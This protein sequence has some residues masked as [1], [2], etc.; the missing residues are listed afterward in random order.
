MRFRAILLASL[1]VAGSSL[2][3]GCQGSDQ[4]ATSPTPADS[5]SGSADPADGSPVPPPSAPPTSGTCDATKARLAIGK[6]ASDELLER[7]RLAA[8][9]R[10]ARFLRPNQPI[11]MEF[12]ASRLNLNLNE[13]GIVYTAYCG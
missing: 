12:L 6:R 13:R 10:V 5:S 9:A 4:N 2:I 3:I 11:T 1:F 8:Q 7:A